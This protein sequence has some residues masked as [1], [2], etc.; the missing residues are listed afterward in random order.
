MANIPI[1]RTVKKASMKPSIL[2]LKW[3]RRKVAAG[4]TER[5]YL[6]F[7][8][9]GNSL[10]EILEPSDLIG[11]LGWGRPEIEKHTIAQLL[12]KE[13]P[14][15]ESGRVPIYICPECGDLGC[16]AVTARIC[17]E[18]ESYIWSDFAFEN[19]YE[20]TVKPYSEI[21]PFSFGKAAYS[22]VLKKRETEI[23]A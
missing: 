5:D 14:E 7:I 3:D 18:A 22:K 20:G 15:P 19:N 12:T 16:G 1:H 2:E 6:D 8:V 21:G 17:E 11:C 13:L 23:A 4:Q 9:N 10:I